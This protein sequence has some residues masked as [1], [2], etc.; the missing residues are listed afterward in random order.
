MVDTQPRSASLMRES[1]R[2]P[3]R[4]GFTGAVA[5][6][7]GSGAVL[8]AA[9][10]LAATAQ[11]GM[12]GSTD[13]KKAVAPTPPPAPASTSEPMRAAAVRQ[14]LDD[15][16]LR[17][18]LPSVHFDLASAAIRPADRKMLDAHA[19]WLKANPGQPVVLEGA[20][21]PRGNGGYNLA[22]GERRARA[23][24]DYLVARGVAPDR[25]TTLSMGEGRQACRAKDCW[26][27]D[28]RVDFLVKDF[29]KQAP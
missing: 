28:R 14:P 12:I 26:G 7:L 22:L 20:A 16:S 1:V 18:E 11:T 15:F 2:P 4:L 24:K 9:L 23:V 8:I 13:T 21:D 19:G 10:G 27:L 25:I 17:T 29:S 3:D 6:L 5:A